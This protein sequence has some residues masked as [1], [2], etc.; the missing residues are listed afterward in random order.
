MTIKLTLEPNTESDAAALLPEQEVRYTP[1]SENIMTN[2][3]LTHF[4]P[5]YSCKPPPQWVTQIMD[6]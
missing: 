4:Y 5:E 3:V 1:K 6:K 2:N